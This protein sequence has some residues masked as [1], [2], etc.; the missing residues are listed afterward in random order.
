VQDRPNEAEARR[1]RD[2]R[3]VAVVLAG[4]MALWLGGQWLGGQLGLEAR[5]A[6]LFDLMAIAG[7]VWALVVT[8]RIWRGRQG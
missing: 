5:Y 3:L 2:A 8:Y 4:T 7:F 6:F 1:A